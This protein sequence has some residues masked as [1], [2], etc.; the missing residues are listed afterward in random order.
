[1]SDIASLCGE[2]DSVLCVDTTFNLCPYWVTDCTYTNQRL[3]TN[4]GNHPIF[5]GPLIIHFEK[6]EIIF[7]RFIS[8]MC[9]FKPK[10]QEIDRIGADL[11]RAIF[12]SASLSKIASLR[13]AFAS[14]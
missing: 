7:R 1:M 6:D 9:C 2:F 13:S 14:K 5:L 10:I 8:E 12:K 11:E 4:S 3:I